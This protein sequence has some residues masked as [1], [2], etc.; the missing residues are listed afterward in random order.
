MNTTKD[1]I[2]SLL[3]KL[4]DDCTFEDVQYHLYV[5]EKIRRGIERAESEGAVSQE[6]AE[7]RLAK[8]TS[9]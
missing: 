3:Q 5:V 6:E 8:W 2:Q 7:R 1:E 9:K 4:P